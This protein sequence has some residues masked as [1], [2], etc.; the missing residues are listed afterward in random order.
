MTAVADFEERQPGASMTSPGT[1]RSD[2]EFPLKFPLALPAGHWLPFHAHPH[3]N[4]AVS[5]R[6]RIDALRCESVELR[7]LEPVTFSLRSAASARSPQVG[8]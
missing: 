2:Q 6:F 8:S 3:A 5:N 7:G 1:E 4:L